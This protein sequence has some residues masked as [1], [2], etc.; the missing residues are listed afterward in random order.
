MKK[1]RYRLE[2]LLKVKEHIEKERQKELAVAL[3]KVN[4]QRDANSGLDQARSS[5]MDGQ[6]SHL[7]GQLSVAEMLVYSRYIVKLKRDRLAGQECLIGLE[8]EAESRRQRLV[9]ASRERQTH[10]KLKEKLREKHVKR[11]EDALQKDTDEVAIT[12]FLRKQK[13]P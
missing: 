8:H 6:R 11:I 2:A 5:T 1:F 3:T 13:T 12:G 10:D 4:N 9:E 7:T